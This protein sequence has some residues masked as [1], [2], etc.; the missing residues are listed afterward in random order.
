MELNPTNHPQNTSGKT[1]GI[2]FVRNPS[3]TCLTV[4]DEAEEI[5]KPM[6]HS[7]AGL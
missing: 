2:F 7:F 5:A 1:S 4:Y 6:I 3:S